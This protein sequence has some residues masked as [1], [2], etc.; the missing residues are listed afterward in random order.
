MNELIA[1]FVILKIINSILKA[2]MLIYN[3][4]LFLIIEN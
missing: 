2:S 4:V 1:I 3:S